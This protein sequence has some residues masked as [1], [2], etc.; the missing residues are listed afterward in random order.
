MYDLLLLWLGLKL[1][2]SFI[3]TSPTPLLSHQT[4]ECVCLCVVSLQLRQ[5]QHIHKHEGSAACLNLC[6]PSSQETWPLPKVVLTAEPLRA[7]VISILS[8]SNVSLV[9]LG[10]L[11][12]LQ[13]IASGF[14]FCFNLIL[15]LIIF[16]TPTTH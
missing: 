2:F 6:L 16:T 11:P 15:V 14:R 8:G 12:D 4:L 10:H 9:K 13:S 3:A 1:M 7:Q 5:Q